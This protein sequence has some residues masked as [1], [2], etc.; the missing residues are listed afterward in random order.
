MQVRLQASA[1]VNLLDEK[2]YE[3]DGMRDQ[4]KKSVG[5][6]RDAGYDKDDVSPLDVPQAEW[7]AADEPKA[8]CLKAGGPVTG[9][10]DPR[11]A[12]SAPQSS[13]TR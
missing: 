7:E 4:W 12:F 1:A 13:I 11:I 9:P 5:E 2:G 8:A 3:A 10:E 6:L